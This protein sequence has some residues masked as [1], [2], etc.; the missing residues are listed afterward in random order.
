MNRPG[1][2]GMVILL[3]FAIPLVVEARTL[4]I[5]F[6]FDIAPRVYLPASAVV[7]AVAFGAIWVFL[8]EGDT[9]G[10]LNRPA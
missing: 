2:T 10:N 7:L 9:Q 5:M 6:G 3:A 8:D 4:F 1:P